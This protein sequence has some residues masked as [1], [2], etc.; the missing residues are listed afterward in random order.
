MI[1]LL[2]CGSLINRNLQTLGALLPSRRRL[3][4]IQN[5]RRFK[6]NLNSLSQEQFYESTPR[7]CRVVHQS[8]E[9]VGKE[10][11]EFLRRRVWVT[12]M[13]YLELL[14]SFKQ[15]LTAK[16]TQVGKNRSRLQ[17]CFTRSSILHLLT[18]CTYGPKVCSIL[19]PLGFIFN[20]MVHSSP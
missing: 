20:V 4:I 15:Q 16:R 5:V 7:A 8:V 6:Y 13:S 9:S 12:P 3:V 19:R 17:V 2:L 10:F 1:V 11:F 14:G 18:A